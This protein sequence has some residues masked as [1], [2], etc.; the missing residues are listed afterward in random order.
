MSPKSF[1]EIMR[2]DRATAPSVLMRAEAKRLEAFIL[3]GDGAWLERPCRARR[4][5]DASAEAL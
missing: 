2:T 3:T 5:R 4:A 1:G